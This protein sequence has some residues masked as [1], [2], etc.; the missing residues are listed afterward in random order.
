MKK[1]TMIFCIAL[2]L[3]L[4]ITGLYVGVAERTRG[5][6]DDDW[7]MG[8][9]EFDLSTVSAIEIET[10]GIDVC[11][12]DGWNKTI[13]VDVPTSISGIVQIRQ[14]GDTLYVRQKDNSGFTTTLSSNPEI[15]LWM[16]K[17]G[18]GT[19][20]VLTQSGD[21]RVSGLRGN[22]I[23]VSLAAVSG[24]I[25]IYGSRLGSLK[26]STTSGDLYLGEVEVYGRMDLDTSSGYL[27]CYD[28]ETVDAGMETT[29]GDV[30]LSDYLGETLSVKT[31]SGDVTLSDIGV[32]ELRAATTSGDIWLTLPGT[33]EDYTVALSTVS[34]HMEG[35]RARTGGERKLDVS[36]VSGDVKVTFE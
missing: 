12:Y 8:T 3:L 20:S 6:P 14:Q 22:D 21:I 29:S 28:V 10:Q 33:E 18:Q 36:T 2:G 25:S 35:V 24:E 5:M 1:S 9:T 19:M 34:G 32:P 7:D 16:P 30:Y 11:I 15:I 23:A 27:N 26:A 31:T 17:G 13:E 4:V